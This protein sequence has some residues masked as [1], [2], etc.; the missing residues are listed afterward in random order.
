M[1]KGFRIVNVASFSLAFAIVSA[2]T[3]CGGV[4]EPMGR[5]EEV[6]LP[7]P[8]EVVTKDV[9]EAMIVKKSAYIYDGIE[10]L[11]EQ[12][13]DAGG[14]NNI[15][16]VYGYWTQ[17][18]NMSR[19]PLYCGTGRQIEACLGGA[20]NVPE[21]KL[22]FLESAIREQGLQFRTAQIARENPANF[23]RT[24]MYTGRSGDSIT[25]SYREFS[26]NIARP[27]FTQDLIFDISKDPVIGVRG[28]RIE[29][30]AADNV[31]ITY[32]VL[33]GF[34]SPRG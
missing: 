3:A 27:A 31:S 15:F 9:G 8:M 7:A 14:C 20:V 26:G 21:R 34:D 23:Q 13:L 11:G 12:R 2:V 1:G 5:L 29:V 32:R 19:E 16:L 17:A 4:V 25:I 6:S 10:F 24:L 22:C 33:K 18:S 30:M 28:A